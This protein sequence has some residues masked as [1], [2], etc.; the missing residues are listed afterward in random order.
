MVSGINASIQ[1]ITDTFLERLAQHHEEEL[2]E[3]FIEELVSYYVCCP[4]HITTNNK[5]YVTYTIHLT[6]Y[7]IHLASYTIHYT[8]YATP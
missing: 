7:T 3:K 4:I 2:E 5:Y 1:G 8:S 6:T